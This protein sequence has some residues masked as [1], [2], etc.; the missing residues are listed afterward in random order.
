[1]QYKVEKKIEGLK[2]KKW[3]SRMKKKVCKIK[4]LIKDINT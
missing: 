4:Y 1:M 3:V 2:S